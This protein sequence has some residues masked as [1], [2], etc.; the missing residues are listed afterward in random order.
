M[1]RLRGGCGKGSQGAGANGVRSGSVAAR[2]GGCAAWPSGGRRRSEAQGPPR[3]ADDAGDKEG[4][5]KPARWAAKSAK[6]PGL[7]ARGAEVGSGAAPEASD[8]DSELTP[9]SGRQ[10]RGGEGPAPHRPSA[11]QGIQFGPAIAA[12]L[13]PPGS[14]RGVYP[15]LTAPALTIWNDTP[16]DVAAAAPGPGGVWHLQLV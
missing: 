14:S 15:P 13:P 9:M 11:A 7:P 12:R 6:T 8:A 1:R 2:P 4:N 5:L 3:R 16:P 10:N